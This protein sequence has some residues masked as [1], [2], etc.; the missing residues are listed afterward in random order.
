LPPTLGHWMDLQYQQ[1][2][3]TQRGQT[4][5]AMRALEGIY[6]RQITKAALISPKRQLHKNY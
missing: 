3:W 4:P 6:S 2:A 5:S 1:K